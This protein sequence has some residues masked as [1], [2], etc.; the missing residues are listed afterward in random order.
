MKQEFMYVLDNNACII[1]CNTH[2][3]T[4]PWYSQNFFFVLVYKK[5]ILETGSM[6]NMRYV[7][8]VESMSVQHMT[9]QKERKASAP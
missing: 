4:V 7:C 6:Y 2:D 1:L 3:S 9:M 8:S 5:H